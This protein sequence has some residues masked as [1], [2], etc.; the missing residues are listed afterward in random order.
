MLSLP[1]YGSRDQ[2]L[3]ESEDKKSK[4]KEQKNKL[5]IKLIFNI[6]HNLMKV[7]TWLL[8]ILIVLMRERVIIVIG[9]VFKDNQ[10]F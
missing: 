4:Y 5:S 9:E 2:H 1:S 10:N 6:I 8:E 3:I 7:S